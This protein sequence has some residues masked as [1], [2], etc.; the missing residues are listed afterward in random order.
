[1]SKPVTETTAIRGNPDMLARL[2]TWLYATIGEVSEQKLI[3]LQDIIE[4]A[5]DDAGQVPMY[6][7]VSDA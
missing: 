4:D 1:M 6:R 3:E 2:R 7:K 5:A